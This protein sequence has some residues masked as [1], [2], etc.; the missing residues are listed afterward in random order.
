[1]AKF[2]KN[3]EKPSHSYLNE[4]KNYATDS[5]TSI[6]IL[7]VRKYGEIFEKTATFRT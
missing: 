1:M 5:I 4:L 7:A 6:E 2:R 3:Q